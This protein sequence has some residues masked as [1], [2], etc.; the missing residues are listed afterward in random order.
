MTKGT[1]YRGRSRSFGAYIN[2]RKKLCNTTTF[3]EGEKF[4]IASKLTSS[5]E[6]DVGRGS[7]PGH[8]LHR[9][10][11]ALR[12]NLAAD[13]A[14]LGVMLR[15]HGGTPKPVQAVTDRQQI[16][17]ALCIV[18]MSYTKVVAEKKKQ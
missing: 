6:F 17:P 7:S 18:I 3:G 13:I 4:R 8:V 14:E 10:L 16:P 2:E 15:A 1:T 5:S 12:A 9:I 11:L